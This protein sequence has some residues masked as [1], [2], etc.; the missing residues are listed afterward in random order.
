MHARP[1]G[2][3]SPR[4]GSDGMV[5][6]GPSNVATTSTTTKGVRIVRS[7]RIFPKARRLIGLN[8]KPDPWPRPPGILPVE[9]MA[10][11]IAL[12][13][14]LDSLVPVGAGHA[15]YSFHAIQQSP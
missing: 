12:A 4:S 7:R 10:I 8:T 9:N 6:A 1:S 11:V 2:G 14:F 13:L 5:A 3:S 15:A